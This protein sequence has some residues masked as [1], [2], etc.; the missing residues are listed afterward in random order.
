MIKLQNETNTEQDNNL[1]WEKGTELIK[2]KLE[3]APEENNYLPADYSKGLHAWFLKEVQKIDPQLSQTLHDEQTEKAFTISRLQGDLT[4][5]N[6]QIEITSANT[7]FWEI[8]AL[9]NSVVNCLEK[10]LKNFPKVMTINNLS[11]RINQVQISETPTTY[12]QLIS[13]K[14]QKTFTLSFIS[15]TSFRRKGHHFPLPVP[16]NLFHSYL[17]RWHD[18]SKPSFPADEFL[19]WVDEFVIIKRHQLQTSKVAGG[20]RGLVTGFT[21]AI[22]ITL[23]KGAESHPLFCQLYSALGKLAPYCGTG[24]KTTFGL[25]QTHRGWIVESSVSPCLT[26]E[27]QL[28]ERIESLTSILLSTQKR[29]DGERAKKICHTKATILARREFGESLQAIADDLEMPYETVK[30]YNKLA[31]R[32]VKN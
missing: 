16:Y 32:A 15:P 9:S 1:T 17:R 27:T 11:F 28:A 10:W 21:G 14:A 29:P 19:N 22:E 4:L 26:I 7:Y 20:K 5:I 12:Q 18:F 31:R 13:E 25:G 30:T 24:H 3:L 8:S 23:A 6:K 2:L